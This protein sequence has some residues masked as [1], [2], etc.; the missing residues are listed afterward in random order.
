MSENGI[1]SVTNNKRRLN[2]VVIAIAAYL[3]AGCVPDSTDNTAEEVTSSL[4][5]VPTGTG[6]SI[7]TGAAKHGRGVGLSD[8]TSCVGKDNNDNQDEDASMAN[9]TIVVDRGCFNIRD[10]GNTDGTPVIMIH[11]WP[12]NSYM[13][14][15]TTSYLNAGLRVIAP[16]LRG[17]GRSER[18]LDVNAYKKEELA[19]DVLAIA[20]ALNLTSFYV[21]GHD[22]GGIVAQEMA[23]LAPTRVTKLVIINIPVILNYQAAADVTTYMNSVKY[24]PYWYQYFQMQPGLAEAMIPGNENVWVP[25][26]FSTKAADGTVPVIPEKSIN[27]YVRAY[28]RANTPATGASYYRILSQD[29]AHWTQL[30]MSGKRFTMPSLF[31]YGN[32]D[33]VVIPANINYLSNCF[34]SITVQQI[35]AAHFVVDEKPQEVAT[36]L[37]NFLG[38]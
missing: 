31:I 29:Q 33:S 18:T 34:D 32:K 15:A 22:W 24:F 13:W 3:L 8:P 27:H 7:E 20:D 23:L 16:D 38:N 5:A 19:K 21:V 12:E 28:K 35:A 26:F 25:Y 30:V 36:L 2:V 6:G 14:K 17:L 4:R 9:R 10:R 1:P 11:G 37:N